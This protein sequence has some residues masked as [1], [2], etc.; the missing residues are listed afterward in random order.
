V[1]LVDTSLWVEHLRRRHEGLTHRLERGEVACHPFIVG[2]ISLGSLRQRDDVLGLLSELPAASVVPQHDMQTLVE[3]LSLAG[4]GI[5]WVDAHLIAS[6]F[7]DGMRLWTLDRRLG[8]VARAI[9]LHA[10]E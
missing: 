9:N 1:I 4:K 3:R 6:A 10:L 7:V 2:E 5:G 8:R